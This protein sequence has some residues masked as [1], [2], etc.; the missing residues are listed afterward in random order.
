MRAIE[1]ITNPN[2]REGNGRPKGSSKEKKIVE[3]WRKN[4]PDGTKAECIR[5]TGLSKP[6][7]YRW[8]SVGDTEYH[9]PEPPE[10]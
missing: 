5:A 7:V 10:E 8:W 6:T 2:W 9:E 1:N 3:E 4:H